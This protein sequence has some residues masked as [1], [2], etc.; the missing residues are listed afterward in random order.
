VSAPGGTCN[1]GVPRNAAVPTT[2][3]FDTNVDG[4]SKTMKIVV[5]V[6][7]SFLGVL[8]NNA[9]PPSTRTT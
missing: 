3:A 6:D 2:C 9:A 8:G 7:P 5:K 4:A 1:A